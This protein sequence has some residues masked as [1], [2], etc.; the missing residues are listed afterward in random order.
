MVSDMVLA[1]FLHKKWNSV[2]SSHTIY[3][4]V[5]EQFSTTQIKGK[6]SSKQSLKWEKSLNND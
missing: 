4:M 1:G 5:W 2:D 3:T 6:K